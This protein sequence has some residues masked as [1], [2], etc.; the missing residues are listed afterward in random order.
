MET[1]HENKT[2]Y[3]KI[4]IEKPNLKFNL[5]IFFFAKRMCW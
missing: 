1:Y 3:E 2:E 4:N 5:L